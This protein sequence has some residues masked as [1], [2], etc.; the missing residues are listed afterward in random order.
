[1]AVKRLSSCERLASELGDRI[2]EVLPAEEFEVT[3]KGSLIKIAGVGK[4]FGN[5]T[6][7]V[8]GWLWLMPLPVDRRLRMVCDMVGDGV[9]RFMTNM[10][11][12]AT[13]PAPGAKAYFKVTDDKLLLWW[14]D[15]EANAMAALRPVLRKAIDI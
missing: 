10:Q 4:K 12:G 15:S 8:L 6:G 1:M 13:W 9:Q 2:R 7:F 14:G 3:T 11:C 5:V